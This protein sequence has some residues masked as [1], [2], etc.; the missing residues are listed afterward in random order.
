MIQ[1][2]L[3]HMMLHPHGFCLLFKLLD[4]V[5]LHSASTEEEV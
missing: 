5:Y 2:D 1:T 3:P 4:M